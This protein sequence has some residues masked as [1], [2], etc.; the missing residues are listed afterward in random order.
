MLPPQGCARTRTL[1]EGLVHMPNDWSAGAAAAGAV[2]KAAIKA[3]TARIIDSPLQAS[4][5]GT[6]AR[7]RQGNK[8]ARPAPMNEG[9]NVGTGESMSESMANAGEAAM[10]GVRQISHMAAWQSNNLAKNLTG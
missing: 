3:M 5:P 9:A 4:M 8:S 7:G 2:S 1:R 10:L 6:I